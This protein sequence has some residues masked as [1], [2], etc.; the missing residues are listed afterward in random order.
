MA[1]TLGSWA[2]PLRIDQ[3]AVANRKSVTSQV[4]D[5]L[6]DDHFGLPDRSRF[7]PDQEGSTRLIKRPEGKVMK[8]YQRRLLL[9]V[10]RSL[11]LWDHKV[12]PPRKTYSPPT[13]PEYHHASQSV[14]KLR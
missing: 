8:S 9:C 12:R 1:F 7:S 4:L 2:L 6:C 13:V 11:A 5:P 14:R 3:T 10:I